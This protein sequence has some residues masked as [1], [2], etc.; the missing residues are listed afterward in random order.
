MLQ[1]S[2]TFPTKH[3]P[4]EWRQHGKH[5]GNF[6]LSYGEPPELPWKG[7]HSSDVPRVQ[8]LHW[9]FTF[10]FRFPSLNLLPTVVCHRLGSPGVGNAV[11]APVLLQEHTPGLSFP[12]LKNYTCR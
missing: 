7:S 8:L 6:L 9:D 4:E 10:S 1:D 2:E 11:R 3:W 5:P 12:S